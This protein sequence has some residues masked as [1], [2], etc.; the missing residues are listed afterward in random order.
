MRG[1]AVTVR[2][3]SVDYADGDAVE[4]WA[5]EEV[6]GVLVA[7]GPT[8]DALDG[9]RPDGTAVAYTLAFP[10]SYAASLRGCRVVVGGEELAVV[11]DPR[12]HPANCPTRWNRTVEVTRVDG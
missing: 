1:Q 3:P 8:R 9:N 6:R 2:R 12:P 5:D 4:T 7:A 11:G 10:K